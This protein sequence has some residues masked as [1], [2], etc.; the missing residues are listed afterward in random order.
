M[1]IY[2][3]YLIY[4]ELITSVILYLKKYHNSDLIGIYI[5]SV[6]LAWK[7]IENE[8][9]G[10]KSVKD[11]IVLIRIGGALKE[12]NPS[13]INFNLNNLK[14]AYII[15]KNTSKLF[16][17]E[18]EDIKIEANVENIEQKIVEENLDS[19]KEINFT[20]EGI[21][22]L[23]NIMNKEKEDGETVSD[24]EDRLVKDIKNEL[25]LGVLFKNED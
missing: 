19:I 20:Q 1:Q 14:E 3:Y 11:K 17:K 4:L 8:L 13:D 25:K 22:S 24:F 7:K 21:I 10:I 15:L 5:D 9:K 2:N 6:N 18:Y 16:S 12:G 23:L